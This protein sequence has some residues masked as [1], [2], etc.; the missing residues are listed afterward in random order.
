[1]IGKKKIGVVILNYKD[2]DTTAKLC[3]TIRAYD[4]ID[5]IV[6]VD[7]LSPDG[8]FLRLKSLLGDKVDVIQSDKNGGYSYGNNFGAFHLIH[9]YH[10]DVLF[11]AN[12]DV[13]FTE[14]FL[15]Q[16]VANMAQYHVQAASGFMRMPAYVKQEMV[17]KTLDSFWGE[18][19]NCTVFAK[20]IFAYHGE[21][22]LPGEGVC[23]VEYLQGSLFAIEASVYQNLQGL[24]ENVFLYYEE[25]ILGRKFL[26]A[27]YRMAV[28]TDISYLHNH[29]VSI[30]KELNRYKQACQYFSSRYYYCTH[31]GC[32]GLLKR[33]ALRFAIVYGLAMRYLLYRVK[34]VVKPSVQ[35]KMTNGGA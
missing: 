2:A 35:S 14:E 28:D 5:H 13:E 11:I 4:S 25:Q 19:L 31:Y 15:K 12:P 17:Y 3:R 16:V 34:A 7:N 8:S 33:L 32:F 24:D 18:V 9:T 1:M 21:R 29:S 30:D 23:F 6:I 20:R 26:G 27:G 22:I 10:I